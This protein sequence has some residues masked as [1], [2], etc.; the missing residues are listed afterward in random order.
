MDKQPEPTKPKPPRLI[1]VLDGDVVRVLNVTECLKG[2]SKW[3]K[4]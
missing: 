1:R 3:G 2:W 4:N